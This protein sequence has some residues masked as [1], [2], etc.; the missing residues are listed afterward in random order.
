MEKKQLLEKMRL[1]KDKDLYFNCSLELFSNFDFITEVIKIFKDDFDFIDEVAERYVKF[2]PEEDINSNPEYIELCMLLGQ[3][4]PEGH[5]YYEFYTNRLN[6][7]YSIFLLHVM[8]VKD[9]LEGVSELGFSILMEDYG[10]RKNILDYFATRLMDELYHKNHCGSFEDLIHKHCDSPQNVQVEGYEQFFIRNL[11]GVDDKL[12]Y[13]VFDNPHLLKDLIEELDEIC[14]NWYLYEDELSIRCVEI[15]KDWVLKKQEESTYGN[16]FDYIQA[17]NEV[18]FSMNF[19][20]MF[21]LNRRDVYANRSK[22]LSFGS[23]KFKRDLKVVID[24]VLMER[25]TLSELNNL[26]L[27]GEEGPKKVLKP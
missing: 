15:V 21:G 14:E 16:D 4:V 23:A 17:M 24:K 1:T 10:D 3:Y 2:I 27:D 9:Q 26:D 19:C 8:M 7:I 13:Y 11:Y 5:Q 18:L 20:E 25:L 22:I 12:S 6:G